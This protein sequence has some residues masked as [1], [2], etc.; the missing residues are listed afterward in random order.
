MLKMEIQTGNTPALILRPGP[1]KGD[2]HLDHILLHW[3][4]HDGWRG[5][6]H[7]IEGSPAEAEVQFIFFKAGYGDMW[8]SLGYSDGLAALGILLN[9]KTSEDGL[10]L[11]SFGLTDQLKNLRSAGSSLLGKNINL[12]SLKRLL[13]KAIGSYFTYPGSLTAPPCSPVVTWIVP[14]S[15]VAIEPEFLAGLR[16]LKDETGKNIN[17]NFRKLQKWDGRT[18]YM[19]KED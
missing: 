10:L 3:S 11:P 5:S 15:P 17:H 12:R 6:D 1:L 14:Q 19:K 16:Q 13:R 8:K 7:Q 4:D 18:I 2:F 9:P